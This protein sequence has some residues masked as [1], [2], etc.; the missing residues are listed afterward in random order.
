MEGIMKVNY[1]VLQE[2]VSD[3]LSNNVVFQAGAP[4]SLESEQMELL[5]QLMMHVRRKGL[6]VHQAALAFEEEGELKFFGSR[7]LVDHLSE[8]GLP[9]WTHSLTLT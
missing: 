2:Q 4:S 8:N 9:G 6:N 5:R 1:A 3:R 7:N